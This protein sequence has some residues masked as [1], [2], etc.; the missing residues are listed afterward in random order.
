MADDERAHESLPLAHTPRKGKRTRS[1]TAR[2]ERSKRGAKRLRFDSESLP[3]E[4]AGGY[5]EALADEAG[6]AR[7]SGETRSSASSWGALPAEMQLHVLNQLPIKSLLSVRRVNS[8]L[9]ALA[10]EVLLKRKNALAQQVQDTAQWHDASDD[11]RRRAVLDLV[12]LHSADMGD[13]LWQADVEKALEQLV[14]LLTFDDLLLANDW[15]YDMLPV[16]QIIDEQVA[17][18]AREHNIDSEQALRYL[19]AGAGHLRQDQERALLDLQ[20][21]RWLILALASPEDWLRYQARAALLQRLRNPDTLGIEADPVLSEAV[22]RESGN[23][24]ALDKNTKAGRQ[25]LRIAR[26]VW[27]LLEELTFSLIRM[28]G[29]P[30]PVWRALVYMLPK[31]SLERLRYAPYDATLPGNATLTAVLS[32]EVM[33]RQSAAES[34]AHARLK[35]RAEDIVGLSTRETVRLATDMLTASLPEHLLQ[36]LLRMRVEDNGTWT[37]IVYYVLRYA[38]EQALRAHEELLIRE[39]MEL[40]DENLSQDISRHRHGVWQRLL[41]SDR[42]G[43]FLEFLEDNDRPVMYAPVMEYEESHGSETESDTDERPAL[44]TVEELRQGVPFDPTEELDE[45]RE[46]VD[47]ADPREFLDYVWA[48]SPEPGEEDSDGD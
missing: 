10:D 6:S 20:S 19:Q 35:E 48:S 16:Q 43:D 3:M 11:T 31:A 44:R 27:K 14:P 38:P 46:F 45:P 26:K 22:N 12:A 8:E 23:P 13:P 25:Q 34:E 39:G 47:F 28:G 2:V 4:S 5:T 37:P 24:E 1:G 18:R 21:T 32:D 17:R 15:A 9:R 7:A 41:R 33:E 42:W 30:E 40:L 36:N 29:A